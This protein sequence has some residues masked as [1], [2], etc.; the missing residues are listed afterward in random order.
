LLADGH[1]RFQERMKAD[2]S[3]TSGD[4]VRMARVLAQY[5]MLHQ[6][7]APTHIDGVDDRSPRDV[8]ETPCRLAPAIRRRP[9]VRNPA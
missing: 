1:H 7:G 5:D 4:T 2:Y 3:P 8:V 9:V 6:A